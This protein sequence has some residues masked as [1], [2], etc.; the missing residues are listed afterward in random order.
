MRDYIQQ[1]ERRQDGSHGAI[2]IWKAA[3]DRVPAK[4]E[5]YVPVENS[6]FWIAKLT[7]LSNNHGQR[8]PA[9]LW[10]R[11]SSKFVSKSK[12]D[13]RRTNEAEVH[14]DDSRNERYRDVCQ[15]FVTLWEKRA[16]FGVIKRT[17]GYSARFRSEPL[18]W[19]CVAPIRV[20]GPSA[21]WMWLRKRCIDRHHSMNSGFT[22]A[23]YQL[24]HYSTKKNGAKE[25]SGM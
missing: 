14:V 7:E 3:S 16:G 6:E 13:E 10:S 8:R 17:V 12:E 4:G 22:D 23:T 2:D 20:R 21:T 9:G 18:L 15:S 19:V 5:L 24:S 11:L 1:I 25:D